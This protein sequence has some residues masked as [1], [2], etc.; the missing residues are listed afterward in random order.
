MTFYF[1]SNS[2]VNDGLFKK[3]VVIVQMQPLAVHSAPHNAVRHAC[4]THLPRMNWPGT[5][6]ITLA[7]HKILRASPLRERTGNAHITHSERMNP[8]K[9]AE[10]TH[11]TDSIFAFRVPSGCGDMKGACE[12]NRLHRP[13]AYL[14]APLC[15]SAL[16]HPR[17]TVRAQSIEPG[18]KTSRTT[19]VSLKSL[20]ESGN[21]ELRH[22]AKP[23]LPYRDSLMS[24]LD[25]AIRR[26]NAALE[27]L[28][29]AA[30]RSNGHAPSPF[31]D[32]L[33][34]ELNALREDRAKLADELSRLNVE[35]VALEGFTEEVAGRLEGAIR[36]IRAV[37]SH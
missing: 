19:T 20:K 29:A 26:F 37:L 16:R 5:A 17:E 13:R 33:A 4:A 1:C 8:R 14:L 2:K 36:E 27:R 32:T 3:K 10:I 6:E 30:R 18:A 21:P 12:I 9:T 34:K 23:E 7:T 22:R 11:I 28:E 15:L 35:K 25:S 31:D 24:R